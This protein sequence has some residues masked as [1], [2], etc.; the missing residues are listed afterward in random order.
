MYLQ[1]ETKHTDSAIQCNHCEN[2]GRMTILA[3]CDDVCKIEQGNS[4]GPAEAGT[5]WELL[6]CE[7]CDKVTLRTGEYVEGFEEDF[8][9]KVIYP[10]R[11][12]QLKGLPDKIQQ[13]YNA[14]AQVRKIDANA[15]AVLIR[16]LLE[17]VC[18]EKGASGKTLAAGLKD[19]AAKGVIPGTLSDMANQVKD[20]GNIGAHAASGDLDKAWVPLLSQ[21][22]EAVLEYVYIAPQRIATA[23]QILDEIKGRRNPAP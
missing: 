6:Q 19:L 11:R 21:L 16:R 8:E 13:A 23:A 2:I 14:A 9:W 20:F 3:K 12:R 1:K 18:L 10:S 15:Y 22:A 5:M 4:Y 7:A 17:M